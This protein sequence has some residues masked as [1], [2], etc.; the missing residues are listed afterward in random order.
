MRP[1]GAT[2]YGVMR[3]AAWPSGRAVM[4][5]ILVQLRTPLPAATAHGGPCAVAPCA[6]PDLPRRWAAFTSIA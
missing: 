4:G 6:M 1:T 3:T 2:R 5:R